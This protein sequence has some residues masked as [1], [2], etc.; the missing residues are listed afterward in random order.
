MSKINGTIL[1]QGVV[2]RCESAHPFGINFNSM[3]KINGT[4]LAQ[5]VVT[6]CES[7]HPLNFNE[8]EY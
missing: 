7:A 3:S 8:D 2:T 5:G 6:R 1:A 4:I